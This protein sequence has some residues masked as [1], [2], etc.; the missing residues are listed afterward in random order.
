MLGF[1]SGVAVDANS[2]YGTAPSG[3]NI[4]LDDLH[5]TGSES[6]IFDCPHSGEWVEN[7][8]ASSIAGVQCTSGKLILKAQVAITD[9]IALQIVTK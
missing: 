5:C 1:P 9:S 7:C 8:Y 2:L 4:V 6:S 3:N